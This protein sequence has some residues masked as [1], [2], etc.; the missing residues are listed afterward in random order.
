MSS[1]DNFRTVMCKYEYNKYTT[2]FDKI[3][4]EVCS[5]YDV[6]IQQSGSTININIKNKILVIRYST[7]SEFNDN[8]YIF[9]CTHFFPIK[10]NLVM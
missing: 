6:S 10:Q 8:N 4:R 3:I 9:K 1:A 7:L 2:I 5:K